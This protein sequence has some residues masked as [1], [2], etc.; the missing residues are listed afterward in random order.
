MINIT[1][2]KSKYVR[3]LKLAE[4]YL[5]HKLYYKLNPILKKIFVETSIQ[6]KHGDPLNIVPTI[7]NRYTN[8]I[9][10]ELEK[11]Y[12]EVGQYSF[13]KKKIKKK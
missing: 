1:R 11:K 5:A 7:V 9:K 2:N 12:K 13:N 6:L 8:P 4:E 3:D 10:T